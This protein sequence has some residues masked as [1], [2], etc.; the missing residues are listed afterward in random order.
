[1]CGICAIG[2]GGSDDSVVFNGFNRVITSLAVSP[3]PV[4]K[5]AGQTQQFTATAT[6]N[7]GT[8]IDVS[9][10][11]TWTSSNPAV[12][13]VT[14]TG[15][16]TAVAPGSAVITASGAGFTDNAAFTVT[17]AGTAVNLIGLNATGTGLV[18]FTST[19]PGAPTNVNITG[20]VA[21]DTLVGI[22]VR[23]QNR[24]LYGLGR[25][26]A[27]GTVRIYAINPDN[28]VA[29]PVGDNPIS[30]TAADGVTPVPVTGT[31]FGFDF[32][33]AV[34]RIRVTTNTSQNFRLNPSL[35]T[36]VDGDTV[37]AGNQ[38][39]GATNGGSTTTD[40]AAYTNNQPNNGGITTLYTLDSVSRSLYIQSP[41][42]NGTQTGVQA[43]TLGGNPLTFSA[44]NGFDIPAG[45]NAAASNVAPASGSG[46]AAL[47]VGGS[48]NLYSINLL[49]GQA[50]LLG[51]LNTNLS[52]LTI[53]PDGAVPA[54]ALDAT[55]TNLVRFSTAT[56]GTTTT[57]AIATASLAAGEELVGIDFRPAT[58]QLY[59][60]AVNAAANTATVYIVDPQTGTLTLPTG[61]TQGAIA[62]VGNDGATPVDLPDPATVGYGVDFNPMVDRLRV[63]TGSGLNFRVNQLNGTP[64]DGNAT[65]AGVQTDGSINGLTTT[66]TGAGYVNNFAGATVTTLY[67]LDASTDS[68]FIQNPPNNGTQTSQVPVTIGGSPVDFTGVNGF[69]IGSSVAV[70]TANAAATGSA[71]A[72]LTIGGV[73]GLYN[74][75][76]TSGAAVNVGNIGAGVTALRGLTLGQGL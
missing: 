34:D 18:R 14:N 46:L 44:A 25:N 24:V 32:N 16:A 20:V 10:A 71:T 39:D 66:A 28:G 50:T 76:L 74:I 55:G 9:S 19:N 13:T 36:A 27:T 42:N 21:G 48:S 17:G 3:K 57:Q 52:G 38:M 45:V 29:N 58:G 64:V 41:P 1:M 68:L 35:G 26:S 15:L 53:L 37:A 5:T 31:G 73:T 67:T 22:D 54:V 8:T 61:A 69:D 33:P 63:V 65:L 43:I 23:P 2:C 6:A 75:N 56:P 70:T 47:T 30:F 72:A 62:F 40:A 59:G 49:N 11:V 51:I 7:D 60:L 12:V 4:T